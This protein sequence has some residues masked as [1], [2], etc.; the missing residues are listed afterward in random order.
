V[1]A[2]VEQQLKNSTRNS[3]IVES[4]VK[5]VLN[6]RYY[7]AKNGA[8]PKNDSF[9]SINVGTVL[10]ITDYKGLTPTSSLDY[11]S[12][13]PENFKSTFSQFLQ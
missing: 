4:F 13:G 11:P 12:F 6:Y 8:G 9:C 1:I 10:Y 2:S 3:P 7:P 5:R